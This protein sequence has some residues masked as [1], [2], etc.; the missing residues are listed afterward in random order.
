MVNLELE[1][2]TTETALGLKWNI[3]E[4]KFVWEVLEKILKQEN[5]K[6]VT[7]RGIVFAV[8]FLFNPLGLITLYVMKAKLLLQTFSRKKLSWDDPLEEA[9]NG[10]WKRWPDDLPKL[11]EIQVNPRD[12]VMLKKYSCTSSQTLPGKDM[13]LLH[14][15]A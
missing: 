13:Q 14:T 7:R 11:Q 4:D 12:L 5:K 8:Y 1:R 10:Q 9:N 15:S 3:E 2:L 6:P